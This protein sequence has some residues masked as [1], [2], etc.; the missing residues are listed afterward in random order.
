MIERSDEARPIAAIVAEAIDLYAVVVGTGINFEFDGISVINAY[1]SREALDVCTA[2][3]AP[4]PNALRGAGQ[5]IF[6]HNAIRHDAL[7]FSGEG[8]LGV[9]R[10][11]WVVVRRG[12]T[13]LS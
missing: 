3:P 7:L 2:Q 5:L 12:S 6:E 4:V 11:D 13:H 10:Q 9:L 1:I 8:L